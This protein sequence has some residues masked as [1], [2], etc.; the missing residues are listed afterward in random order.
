MWRGARRWSRSAAGTCRCSIPPGSCRSTSPPASAAGLFD[1]SHMGRFRVR[2]ADALPFLQHVLSEQR[3]RAGP[4]E[5]QYTLLPTETGG[6]VD[7]AYLYRFEEDEYL[8]V[9]NAANTETDWAHLQALRTGFSDLEL[10]DATADL[11]MLALPG[12][13]LARPPAGPGRRRRAPRAPP[14]RLPHRAPRGEG[15]EA[16][17]HRLH[18][19]AA[20]LRV[21]PAA[22]HAAE[23]WDLLLARGRDTGRPRRAGHAA[24]GGRPAAVRTR[25]RRRPRRCGDPD[26]RLQHRP[27]GR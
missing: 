16:R 9:V 7:D 22:E 20:L 19:R 2:G 12:P 26:L 13:A 8:L 5:A 14:Q 27:P 10:A 23:V 6:A 4:G 21:V 17:P 15:G 3:G 18:R 1:V 25:A 24:P 11:A